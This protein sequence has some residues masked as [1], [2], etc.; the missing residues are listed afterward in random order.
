MVNNIRIVGVEQDSDDGV[1]VAFSDGTIGAYVVEELLDLRPIRER[2]GKV[3]PTKTPNTA[4][5]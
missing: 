5:L 1:I 4:R 3:A 2:V